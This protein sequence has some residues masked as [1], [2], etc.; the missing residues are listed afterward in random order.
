VITRTELESLQAEG[1]R[2]VV[3]DVRTPAEHAQ[4]TVFGARNVPAVDL[5]A[6]I[7]ALPRD[8][9]VVAVCNHGGPRSQGAAQVLR[10]AGLDGRF[11]VGGVHG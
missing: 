2:V 3:L 5:P 1:R 10:D 9:V 6:A 4:G 8:A 7:P 11:L